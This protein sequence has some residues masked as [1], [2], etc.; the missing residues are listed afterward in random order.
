MLYYVSPFILFFIGFLVSRY[1]KFSTNR[2]ESF[3]I[4]N[5]QFLSI[6]SASIFSL[7]HIVLYS[8]NSPLL[9]F[10][11]FIPHFIFAMIVTKLYFVFNFKYILV[12]HSVNNGLILL[13]YAAFSRSNYSI[14]YT[15]F[16]AVWNIGLILYLIKTHKNITYLESMVINIID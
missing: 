14:F 1:F 16:L 11:N 9:L 7:S 3:I 6:I 4:N 12:F 10:F 15:I 5:K 2:T 8:I 13:S